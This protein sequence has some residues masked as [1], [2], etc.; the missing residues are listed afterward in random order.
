M[1]KVLTF[2]LII[3]SFQSQ[4]GSFRD[5]SLSYLTGSDYKVGP[6]KQQVITFEYTAAWDWGDM[7]MFYDSIDFDPGGSTYYGEFSPRIKIKDFG[8][9]GLISKMY[10]ATTFERGKGGLVSNLYGVGF[11]INTESFRYLNA[12]VYQ[13]DNADISGKG[14]QLTSSFGYGTKWGEIPILID[15]YLDWVFS[16]DETEDHF[17][18][19]PQIKIDMKEWLGTSQKWY[20]GIEYD[21]WYQKFGIEDSV[22]DDTNQNTFSFLVKW[23]F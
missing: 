15:G 21:Y 22:I 17:H 1:N 13:R 18:L 6:D 5:G 12:N 7:F 10:F 11:S 23:H 14:Y 8:K 9:N 16:S 20:I 2:V 3:L 4:A 19:N